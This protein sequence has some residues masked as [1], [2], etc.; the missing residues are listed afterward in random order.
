MTHD[1]LSTSSPLGQA[2][3]GAAPGATVT[4]DGPKRT[5]SVTVV[6]IRTLD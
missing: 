1:V 2:L 4:Y 3:L 6:G 5:M